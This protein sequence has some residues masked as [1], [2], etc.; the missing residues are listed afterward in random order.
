[1]I[2]HVPGYTYIVTYSIHSSGLTVPVEKKMMM[3][4]CWG[5]VHRVALLHFTS[6]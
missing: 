2:S 3:M 1:M 6:F 4:I 5:T